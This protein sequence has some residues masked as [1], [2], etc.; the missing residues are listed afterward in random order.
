MIATIVRDKLLSLNL[1]YPPDDPALAGL[2]I[3]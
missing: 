3:E 2:R 1:R